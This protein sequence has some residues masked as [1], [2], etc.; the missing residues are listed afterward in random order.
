MTKLFKKPVS[1]ILALLLIL[2]VFTIV[3]VSVS[4]DT[5]TAFT[6]LSGSGGTSSNENHAKLLDGS[7]STKWCCSVS[8]STTYYV[9]FKTAESVC[10]DSYSLTTAND[11]Q[12]NPSRNWKGWTIYGANFDNDSQAARNSGSWE[13]IT[14]VTNDD[15]LQAANYTTYTYD[16]D[17]VADS[18][19]Y[20][21]IE[22]TPK[23]NGYIQMSEFTMS[24]SSNICEVDGVTF[25]NDMTILMSYPSTKTD[26]FY[27]VPNT[28][29][30]I[31]DSAFD[32]CD[33]LKSVKIPE[34]VT[35]IGNSAFNGCKNLSSVTIPSTVTSIGDNAFKNCSHL[36]R[37][38]FLSDLA[39]I[40]NNAFDNCAYNLTFYGNDPST[41]KTYAQNSYGTIAFVDFESVSTDSD[42]FDFEKGTIKAYYDYNV[43]NVVI[44]TRINN[45]YVY[46]IGDLAF[47]GKDVTSVVIPDTVTYI[48]AGAF[49][50]CKNL[51]S[52]TLGSGVT[53]IDDSAFYGCSSLTTIN[54]PNGVTSIGVSAFRGCSSLSSISIP[55]SVEKIGKYAFR[56]CSSLTG[57]TIPNSITTIGENMFDGCTSL[58]SVSLGSGVKTIG[59]NAFLG[60]SSLSSISIPNGVE[61]IDDNAFNN[62]A[63]LTSLTIPDSV[64]TIGDGAFSGC[65]NITTLS[66]SGNAN[67]DYSKLPRYTVTDLTVTGTAVTENAMSGFGYLE[68]VIIADSVTSIGDEAFYYHPDLANVT[69]GSGVTSIGYEAFRDCS[70]LTSIVIPDN[71]K[72][73]GDYAFADCYNLSSVTIG[74]GVESIGHHAFY[75]CYYLS[76]LTI[77]SGVKSIGYSAFYYCS[78]LTSVTLPASLETLGNGVFSYCYSLNS[79][80][81]NANNPNFS[82]QNGILYNKDKTTLVLYP[83]GKSGSFTIPSTVTRIGDNAF[84][85]CS[86]L[87]G[88]TIPDSVKNIGESAF[89]YCTGL[90]SITIPDSVESIDYSAFYGCYNATSLS[91]GS[92]IKSIAESA[93]GSCSGLTSVTIP[94]NVES[95]G[96]S[97]FSYCYNLTDIT[98]PDSVTSI[99]RYA[100]TGSGITSVTIPDTVTELEEGVFDYCGSLSSV[101]IPNSV[102]SIG[103]NAFYNC[104]SLESI[105]I[106]DSVTEIKSNAFYYC[107]N[108]S[109]VTFLSSQTTIGDSAFDSC[110]YPLTFYG[111]DP[112]PAKDYADNSYG[113]ITFVESEDTS[114]DFDFTLSGDS[115]TITNYKGSGTEA[116]IPPTLGG[117]P[118]TTIT[119]DAFASASSL[120]KVIIPRSV[121]SIGSSAFA[122]CPNVTICGYDGSAAE[123]YA[124]TNNLPFILMVKTNAGRKY[125]YSPLTNTQTKDSGDTS[126]GLSQANYSNIELLGAQQKVGSNG[127]DMRFIAVVNEGIIKDA[128]D[129][130]DIA[131]YGFVVAKSDYKSSAQTD[132]SY[133]SK[134]ALGAPKTKSRSCFD[135]ENSFSGNYGR[136]STKTKY[137]YVTLAIEDVPDDQGFVVRFYIKT[138][139]GKVYYANYNSGYTGC[140]ASYSQV[141]SIIEG[142]NAVRYMDD[143]DSLTPFADN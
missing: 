125:T 81:V 79:V 30:T 43:L 24:V 134:V 80:N 47:A 18:Y 141:A 137:K 60:C 94:D 12:Q 4:A 13:V 131:D 23:A 118:V 116:E 87:T 107:Y 52:V 32:G 21:K 83:Y 106:P 40:G 65:S 57:I 5:Y 19:M 101:T 74:S 99:G 39:V 76:E 41:A 142:E 114:T 64:K 135:T 61:T 45:Q 3:P 53:E 89:N 109:S 6:V 85:N 42:N 44:P 72:S 121:T 143:W 27:T 115:A 132:N 58:S 37:V 51:T 102:T 105:T 22:V 123:A 59:E 73:I 133:I 63:G 48:G 62:C 33:N 16:L 31:W 82:S 103:K 108:L 7:T 112:S 136:K 68:N 95:I 28:V 88:I 11:T 113:S 54:I 71:V 9:V 77:G 2:S 56:D 35:T 8:A 69:I 122:N 86:N 26:F 92:G 84:D 91:I 140:V 104:S 38:A 139:S 66:V 49:A 36:E 97:A 50:N 138:K 111:F 67:F 117:C 10:M 1:I 127:N 46:Y 120:S 93:F 20:Y 124:S 100:F 70:S 119:N 34:G 130:G 128:N 96:D 98:I 29:T 110:Y 129:G 25:N 15:K 126:F 14:T 78:S 17:S 75:D 90:S 55:S